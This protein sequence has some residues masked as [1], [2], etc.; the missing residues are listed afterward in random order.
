MGDPPK[1]EQAEKHVNGPRDEL[2][3]NILMRRARRLSIFHGIEGKAD[4]GG[5]RGSDMTVSENCLEAGRRR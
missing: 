3:R 4:A 2:V 1:R 5:N